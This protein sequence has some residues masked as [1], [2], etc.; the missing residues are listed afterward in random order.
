M[1]KN[2]LKRLVSPKTW[3]IER[4]TTTFI[5]RPNPGAHSLKF[6]ISINTILKEMLK[7]T[8]TTKETRFIL[9]SGEVLVDSKK[10]DDYRFIV[11]LMDT[12]AIQKAKKYFRVLL[13]EKGK[14]VLKDIDEKESS[15]KVCKIL[16]KTILGKDKVQINFNDGRNLLLKKNDYK[17]GD[18]LMM[19]LP[20]QEVKE[21]LPLG[22]K[23][24]IL[25]MGGK[26]MG[27]VGTIEDISKDSIIFKDKKGESFETLKKFAFVI[28]K[29]KPAIKIES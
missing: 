20:K 29:D 16:N 11:G 7:L 12:I 22:K 25:L 8:K 23:A 5:T 14:L 1:T 9:N 10:I 2:H 13:N 4:K 28:G 19:G 17:V 6:G 15:I 27:C 18:S 3:H 26:H 21:H 24:T